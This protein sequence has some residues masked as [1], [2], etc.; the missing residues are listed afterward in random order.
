MPRS[1][2]KV[3]TVHSCALQFR[4]NLCQ[5]VAAARNENQVVMIASEEFGEF[6]SDAAGGTCDQDSRHAVILALG[7]ITERCSARS[8]S[9]LHRENRH[10]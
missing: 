9:R 10:G 4:R 3:L 7:I 2:A 5:P 8:E 6:I 1:R